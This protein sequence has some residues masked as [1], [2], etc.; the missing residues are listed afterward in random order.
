MEWIIGLG[1]CLVSGGNVFE[2]LG[3]GVNPLFHHGSVFDE[4][5]PMVDALPSEFKVVDNVNSVFLGP[6]LI[7]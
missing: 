5:G 2:L 6:L 4:L 3:K 7:G 1:E